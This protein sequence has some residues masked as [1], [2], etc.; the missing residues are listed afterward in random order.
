MRKSAPEVKH[1]KFPDTPPDVFQS[2]PMSAN[3]T[4]L[5]SQIHVIPILVELVPNVKM[6]MVMPCVH[7]PKE[8]V[9]ILSLNALKL[10]AV[11]L[12]F[13]VLT[14]N[15]WKHMVANLNVYVCPD[16]SHQL[17]LVEVASRILYNFAYPD[18][19]A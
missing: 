10:L 12:M 16:S 1:V 18:L 17:F 11:I 6:I 3:M 5:A 19:V 8:K 2:R 15:V 7:V 4:A 13:V 14:L 9:E